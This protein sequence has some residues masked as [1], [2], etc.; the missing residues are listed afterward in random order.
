MINEFCV[1]AFFIS[2]ISTLWQ[3]QLSLAND[4]AVLDHKYQHGIVEWG[5]ES[6]FDFDNLNLSFLLKF[7]KVLVNMQNILFVA[8]NLTPH[9]IGNPELDDIQIHHVFADE[10]LTNLDQL[11]NRVD[12]FLGQDKFNEFGVKAWVLNGLDLF[13]RYVF[14]TRVCLVQN[15]EQTLVKLV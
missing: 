2:F 12:Q 9:Q 7:L 11:F 6:V 5:W 14:L 1:F 4:P 13:S 15:F 10:K 8:W 3:D